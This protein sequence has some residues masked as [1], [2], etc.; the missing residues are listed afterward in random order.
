MKDD[1]YA[2][3]CETI[4]TLFH[5]TCENLSSDN[6]NRLVKRENGPW[7]WDNCL[8]PEVFFEA[9]TFIDVNYKRKDCD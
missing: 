3:C 2:I 8:E 4:S 1:D 9:K 7:I 6:V 5:G